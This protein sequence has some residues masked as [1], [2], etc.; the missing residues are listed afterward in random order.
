MNL[1]GAE[2]GFLYPK[3]QVTNDAAAVAELVDEVRQLATTLGVEVLSV[4]ADTSPDVERT[5]FR[6]LIRFDQNDS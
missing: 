2:G 4:D 6:E 3:L 1:G 5:H